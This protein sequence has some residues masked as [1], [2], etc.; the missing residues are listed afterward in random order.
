MLSSNTN[1]KITDPE[2]GLFQRVE[3]ALDAMR[4]GRGVILQDDFDRENEADLIF[5]AEKMTEADMALMIRA[6]SGIVCLCLDDARIRQ[7]SLPP[8]VSNNESRFG[9][10]FTVS[11]EARHGVTTGVSAADRLTTIRA[12]IQDNAL[13]K[14][15]ARPGHVFPLR[16]HPEGVLGRMGH[17]EGSV[18]LARLAGLKPTAV[19]CELM[20]DDG[21]M[22]RGDDVDA[23]ACLHDFPKL[24]IAELIRFRTITGT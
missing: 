7:L 9:T 15:L 20:R 18:D 3:F 8:M 24:S 19:L 13:P 4:S 23:F 10:A 21:K 6:C 14:D 11:I 17:T 12:A 1:I 22:M 16:A 5:A 2:R